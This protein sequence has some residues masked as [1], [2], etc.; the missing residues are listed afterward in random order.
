MPKPKKVFPGEAILFPLPV[1]LLSAGRHDGVR[2]LMTASWVSTVCSEPPILALGVRPNRHTHSLIRQ[3]GELAINLPDASLLEKLDAAGQISGN[4]GDK[5]TLLGLTPQK[6]QV[7][8]APLVAECPVNLE[9]KV[10][11]AHRLGSHDLFL[12]EVVCVHMSED[13][14]YGEGVAETVAYAF[15]KYY[16]LRGPLAEQGF[17]KKK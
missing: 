12:A 11:Q 17:T 16:G 5:F 9:C 6:A 8:A 13:Y 14:R 15:G 4:D 10:R 1:V 2:G 7:I 3:R